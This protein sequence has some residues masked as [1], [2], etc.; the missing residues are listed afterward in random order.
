MLKKL[1]LMVA[2]LGCVVLAVGP[3]QG[4]DLTAIS[5]T[6]SSAKTRLL[7]GPLAGWK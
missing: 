5:A 1:T 4:V 7:T 6:W 2:F 3:L